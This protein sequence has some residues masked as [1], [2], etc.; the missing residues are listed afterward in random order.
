MSTKRGIVLLLLFS[1]VA[2]CSLAQYKF[3]SIQTGNWNN[4]S[5]W[6]SIPGG[7]SVPAASDTVVISSGHTVTLTANASC[8]RLDIYGTL[9][10]AANNLTCSGNTTLFPVSSL[11]DNNIGGTSNLTHLLLYGGSLSGTV[12][13]AFN[14]SGNLIVSNAT[15]SSIGQVNLTV[16]G[17]TTID[18][19]ATLTFSSTSG[20][21]T[22]A[23]KITNNGTWNC[24]ANEDITLRGGLENNGNF[25]SGSGTYTFNTNSQT[26]SGSQPLT[27][28]GNVAFGNSITLTNTTNVTVNGVLNSNNNTS[29]WVNGANSS[30]RYNNTANVLM[31]T[32]GNLNASAIGN[33]VIYG[34][35]GN[36][37]I[38]NTT[39]YNL[40]LSGSGSKSLGAA[41][42]V[43]NQLT[44]DNNVNFS[45]NNYTFTIQGN[46]VNNNTGDN[47]SESG[48]VVFNGTGTQT[49]QEVSPFSNLTKSGTGTLRLLGNLSLSGTFTLQNGYVDGNEYSF[50]V[51]Q[52]TAGAVNRTGGWFYNGTFVR[53]VTGIA[54]DYL[55]PV[56]TSSQYRPL[57]LNFSSLTGGPNISVQFIASSPSGFVP[58]TDGVSLQNLFDDGYWRLSNTGSPTGSYTLTL[59]GNGF[60][61]YSIDN[62]CRISGRNSSNTSWR[63]MGSHG[64]VSGSTITRTGVATFDNSWIE[65]AFAT[66]CLVNRKLNVSDPTICQTVGTQIT[67]NNS[68]V[69]VTY[70]LRLDADNSPIGSAVAG[71]GSNILVPASPIYPSSSTTYNVLATDNITGC[72]YQLYDKANVTVY[73]YGGNIYSIASGNWNN[74]NIWSYTPGGPSCG[75]VPDVSSRV[76]IQNGHA[77]NLNTHASVSD[78]FIASGGS[79]QLGANNLTISDTCSI[80]GIISDNSATG[81]NIFAG[82]LIIGNSG[83]LDFSAG[84]PGVELRRGLQ[85]NG[86]FISGSGNWLLTT[87]SQVISGSQPIVFSGNVNIAAGITVTN[88]NTSGGS[89]LTF[90]SIID[91]TNASSILKNEGILTFL[92][93]NAP[94]WPGT[95]NATSFLGNIVRYAATAPQTMRSTNYHH[96]QLLGSGA[97]TF[98]SNIRIYG[99]LTINNATLTFGSGAS[100]TLELVGDLNA[101]AGAIDMNNGTNNHVLI[102]KGTNNSCGNLAADDISRVEYRGGHNQQVFASSNYQVLVLGGSGTKQLSG[103]IGVNDTLRIETLVQTAGNELF[104]VDPAAE[105]VRN[106]GHIIGTL[107]RAVG[108][109]GKNYNFPVGTAS[110]YHPAV[111]NFTSLTPGNITVAF[112]PSDIGNTGLP[113]EDAGNVIYDQFSNGYWQTVAGG[114]FVSTNYNLQ[115][116]ATGFGIDNAS[117][118]IRRNDGGSLFIQGLHGSVSGNII[119]RSGLDGISSGTSDFAIGKGRPK[120]TLQPSDIILCQSSTALFVCKASGHPTLTYQWYKVPGIALTNGGNIAGANSDSLKISMVTNA[121]EGQYYCIVTDGAGNTRQSNNASLTVDDSPVSGDVNPDTAICYNTP[122][123]LLSLTGYSGNIVKWQYSHHPYTV[124]YDIS[125]ITDTYT[126]V[127]LT[128]NTRFRAV[129]GNGVCPE[130]ISGDALVTI[131]TEKPVLICPSNK[132]VNTDWNLCSYTHVD[133][134]WDANISD[135]CSVAQYSYRLEG[136]TVGTGTTLNGTLF[137]MGTTTV[138]WRATDNAG[139]SDSCSFD[140][141]VT[142]NQNPILTPISDRTEY[143]DAS[144]QFTIPD[145]RGLTTATDNCTPTAAIVKTQK[146][147]IGTILSGH[148]TTQVVW[149]IAD[150]GH[151]NRDSTSF[152]VTLNDT[153]DP[154]LTPIS[155]RTEYVDAGCQFVIPDYRGLTTAT[156]NCTPTAT[157]VKTQK[158]AIGTILSGHG[159]TQVEWAIADDGHGNRD[160]TSFTVTLNDTIDPDLTPISNRTEYVDASCQF[161]IPDYTNLTTAT[162]NCTPTAAIVKTQRP[163]IGTIL[164]G[165]GTTQVVW[166]IADDGHGNRDSTSF[167]VTLNDTIDPDLTPIS[168]RTEYVDA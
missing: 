144:C 37:T 134:T 70:Q 32:S 106:A 78:L 34:G 95:L 93:T 28:G 53:T 124:W 2:L 88:Q 123:G 92:G 104:I 157:I 68:Q 140:V 71:T 29:T 149:I 135:N 143:V 114:G 9:Q 142:D 154:D 75:L 73:P 24:S 136:A 33:T 83:Q 17:Q 57:I 81:V 97:K 165:H 74:P 72:S 166:V 3:I 14:I 77:I 56:G 11:T 31:N 40:Q 27:F 155:D 99:N 52:G 139:N 130:V 131:E 61:S 60:N 163:A 43:I 16:S 85:N 156:D 96:L 7:G 145:Y 90:Q 18:A 137:N 125:N 67:V 153:I 119:T 129:I 26:L 161:A 62:N 82:L 42:T 63:A 107:K 35:G 128:Q 91:G 46:W 15:E 84:N 102:L 6:T 117:R 45:L 110:S 13:D 112:Q 109:T 5:T 49:V 30:L 66:P 94:M 126:S 101:A 162:D 160:S 41:T 146:P 98:N 132:S 108:I 39:Y 55:F 54:Q 58:Y 25:S 158:P 59:T 51:T 151:G 22:F 23:G 47:F 64:T 12:T 111:F 1:G 116:E 127:N 167:T 164:S 87:N 103:N 115:L 168:N 118:I 20:S 122:S 69:N 38:K 65:F 10:V 19:G 76:H 50:T 100:Y 138:W 159:T 80:N 21:K 79:L 120:I 4:S 148:G 113:L 8:S 147:A 121:D 86:L 152:T 105:V 133:N 89:G 48:T 150:D 141:V 36:Q 44:I